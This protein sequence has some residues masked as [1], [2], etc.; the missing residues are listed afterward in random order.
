MKTD[1]SFEPL[2]RKWLRKENPSSILEWGPGKSTSIFNNECPNAKILSIESNKDY[3]EKM[4]SIHSYAEII[5]API[6]SYGPSEY[7][8]WPL[9]HRSDEKYDL[10]F[11]DGRQRVSCLVSSMFLLTDSGIILIHDSE[12]KHYKHGISLFEVIDFDEYTS[13]LK[14]K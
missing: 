9:L 10:I 13:V 11:I 4:E 2:L 7:S 5:L 12:R 3:K 14:L 8:C 6:P 1:H